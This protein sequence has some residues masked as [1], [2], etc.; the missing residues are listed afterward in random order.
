MSANPIYLG[1][2]GKIPLSHLQE[3]PARLLNA[4]PNNI[5]RRRRCRHRIPLP[6]RPP[7]Q[8]PQT[9]PPRPFLADPP[10]SDTGLRTGDPRGR[11]G[12]RLCHSLPHQDRRPARRGNRYI[13]RLRAGTRHP[14]R[15]HLRHHPRPRVPHIPEEGRLGRHPEQEGFLR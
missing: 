12:N 11:L 1:V 8:C 2:V 9:R 13:P 3:Q 10:R 15:Q 5:T 14:G 7:P 4:H 6:T